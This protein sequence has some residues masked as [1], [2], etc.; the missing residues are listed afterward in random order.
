MSTN[1]SLDKLCILYIK[2]HFSRENVFV[3]SENKCITWSCIKVRQ[4]LQNKFS[5]YA[6]EDKK[7]YQ[8]K[9]NFF[10]LQI[11]DLEV[12]ESEGAPPASAR[13]G[14]LGGACR[15]NDP[16]VRQRHCRLRRAREVR[17]GVLIAAFSRRRRPASLTARLRR[18]PARVGARCGPPFSACRF[19]RETRSSA[20][21]AMALT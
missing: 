20:H 15:A 21:A 2:P 6:I 10:G 19:W 17:L 14:P 3:F 1:L 7:S 16:L 11:L 5:T 8:K 12:G 4:G 18:T 9:K 13:Q